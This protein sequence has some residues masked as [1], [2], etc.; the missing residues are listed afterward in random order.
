M[1]TRTFQRSSILRSIRDI[2][3]KSPIYKPRKELHWK[4]QGGILVVLGS[5]WMHWVT[6][7]CTFRVQVPLGAK[8]CVPESF[9]CEPWS[10]LLI[11][12]LNRESIGLLVGMKGV[13][14]VAH[15]LSGCRVHVPIPLEL[16]SS[17]NSLEGTYFRIVTPTPVEC[18]HG[19]SAEPRT[20]A[21]SAAQP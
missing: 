4:V 3:S 13:F 8:R 19:A 10:K 15:I 7:L 6:M 18:R 14:A 20:T 9:C 21:H 5:C 2:L 17:G 1:P 11:M 12:A 16:C